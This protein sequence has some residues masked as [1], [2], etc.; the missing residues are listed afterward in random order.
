MIMIKLKSANPD[1]SEA[2]RVSPNADPGDSELT[3]EAKA[4][5]MN[6]FNS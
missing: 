4:V 3:V 5:I 6:G 1:I 2:L